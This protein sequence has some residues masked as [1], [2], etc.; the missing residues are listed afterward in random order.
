MREEITVRK[1]QEEKYGPINQP[2][3]TDTVRLKTLGFKNSMNMDLEKFKKD[4]SSENF[5][6]LKMSMYWFQY[7]ANKAVY[8]EVEE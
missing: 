2:T 3:D 4:P 8:D 7:W 1:L 5:S 6:E